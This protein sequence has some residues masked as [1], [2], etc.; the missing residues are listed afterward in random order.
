MMKI[1]EITGEI[2]SVKK[3]YILTHTNP[4]LDAL[5]SSFA[6]CE[7]LEEIGAEASVVLEQPLHKKYDFLEAEYILPDVATEKRT[8]IVLDCADASRLRYTGEIF[9]NA[10][11]T[12]VID[13]HITNEGFGK[14]YIVMGNMSSA[15]EIVYNIIKESNAPLNK[16]MAFF[17][18]SS[19]MADTGGLRY[20]CTSP[21]TLRAV[22]DIMEQNIDIAYINRMIFENNPPEKLI[23]QQKVLS[24]LKFTCNK[25]VAIVRLT[26]DML[27]ETGASEELADA[28]VNIP[29][30]I[31]GVEVGVFLKERAD[32]IKISLRSNSYADVSEVAVLMGGGGHKHAS[33]FNFT[34]TMDEA[35]KTV[36]EKI[37][38]IL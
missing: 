21:D 22:A 31:E 10:D 32:E 36:V 11:S 27:E 25:K 15:G 18:Y 3:A 17:L 24:T 7:L 16:R 6:M 37:C 14:N 20:S 28:F 8:V 29:R 35:E 23:L 5:G 1:A 13:H 26:L 12:I 2:L 4:D 34:G 38:A 33:G 30:G 9:E 19:I